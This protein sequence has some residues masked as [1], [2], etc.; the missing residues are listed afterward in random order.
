MNSVKMLSP[1]KIN[2]TLDILGVR[3]DGYHELRSIVQPIDLFDEIKIETEEGRGVELTSSGISVPLDKTN[4]AWR[5][6]ELFLE[7]SGLELKIKISIRKQIPPGAGLGGG[8]GNAAAVLI[9]LNR[10]TKTLTEQELLK[11]ALNLG[12]DVPFFIRSQT[13]LME[14]VGEEINPLRNFPLFHYVILCPNIHTSTEEV[15]KKWDE[16]NNRDIVQKES[17]DESVKQ[18][19]VRRLDPPLKNDLESAAISLHPEIK[20]YKQILTSLGLESVS[21]TGSGSA[22]YAVFRTLEEAYEI[23]DYLNTSPTFK[24]FLASGIKGWHRLL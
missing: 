13:A 10:I 21:M 15:Y 11:L 7:K 5:A 2:L 1:A 9:G 6:A 16:L 14:G 8:S 17:I 19:S 22:V 18:F 3:P 23:Y 24:V 4:L 20:A 12:A